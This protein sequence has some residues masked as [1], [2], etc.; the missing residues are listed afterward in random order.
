MINLKDNPQNIETNNIENNDYNDYD[1]EGEYRGILWN[2]PITI[3]G[4]R[5][6][7][8]VHGKV[9]SSGDTPIDQGIWEYNPKEDA[10]KYFVPDSDGKATY[11]TDT[12]FTIYYQNAAYTYVFDHNGKMMTGY[13]NWRGKNYYAIESGQFKGAAVE[14]N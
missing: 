13:F 4:V 9:I 7:F 14:I 8:D 3:S 12:S 2:Q 11:Y 1:N 10:W 6:L 5:Y